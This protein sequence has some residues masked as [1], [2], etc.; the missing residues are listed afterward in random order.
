[1]IMGGLKF[2]WT[3]LLLVLLSMTVSAAPNVAPGGGESISE[4]VCDPLKAQGVTKGLYGLCVAFC[5]GGEYAAHDVPLTEDE[6]QA[7]AGKAPSGVILRN[8]HR[9]KQ[10]SDPD[11]PCIVRAVADAC[12]CWSSSELLEVSDGVSADSVSI[13]YGCVTTATGIQVY[14]GEPSDSFAALSANRSR[15][16]NCYYSNSS[17]GKNLLINLETEEQAAACRSQITARCNQIQ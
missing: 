11:M 14:E 3:G 7:L 4:S 1:M 15:S 12:P 17:T 6:L 16:T 13:G 5:E 9:M 8:Y 10:A 2:H